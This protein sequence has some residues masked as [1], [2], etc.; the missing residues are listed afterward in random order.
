[1]LESRIRA[2]VAH[3]LQSPR[4]ASLRGNWF[5]DGI[6]LE[7]PLLGV[8]FRI[9]A[10]TLG[11]VVEGTR[12]RVELREVSGLDL[13]STGARRRAGEGLGEP[14]ISLRASAL[15]LQHD[16]SCGHR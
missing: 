8:T 10:F 13:R 1:M 6:D 3:L 9:F 2:F 16:A 12:C 15:R 7:V 5:R 14:T 4:R 11:S